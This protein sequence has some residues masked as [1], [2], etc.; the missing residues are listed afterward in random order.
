MLCAMLDLTI[1]HESG[2]RTSLDDVMRALYRKHYQQKRR[3]FTDDEFMQACESAAGASLAEVLD[4]ASLDVTVTLVG[5][6]KQSF[7]IR[8][9]ATPTAPQ[10]TIFGDWLRRAR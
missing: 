6:R 9:M 8:R 7:T 2:N 10:E 1:R 4:Y 5:N 3:G